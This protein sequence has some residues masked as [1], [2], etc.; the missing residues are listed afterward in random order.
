MP[1]SKP[2]R[3]TDCPH[4]WPRASRRAALVLAMAIAGAPALSAQS[5]GAAPPVP[6]T[7]GAWWAESNATYTDFDFWVGEWQV[8]DRATQELM[9]YDRIE[10]DFGGCSLRQVWRQLND[11]PPGA[12]RRAHG[13]S[14]STLGPDGRWHQIWLDDLGSFIHTK[15]RLDADGAMVLESDWVEVTNRQ[16]Q[17]VK[18]K[19]R[20][21]WQP[22]PD[23]TIHNWGVLATEG[24]DAPLWQRF[25]DVDYRRNV[26]G[27]PRAKAIVG[28]EP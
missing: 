21:H 17:P 12:P 1:I 13:G 16:G 15:G 11:R 25:F 2:H 26:A 20:F 6:C 4:R 28:S 18:L 19:Y 9:G 3:P 22:K 7:G 24:G 23:G 5:D 27:G 14:H 10:K 8:Y